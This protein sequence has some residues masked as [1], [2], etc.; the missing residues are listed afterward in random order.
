MTRHY[1]PDFGYITA[2]LTEE[3]DIEIHRD[4]SATG[5]RTIMPLG[6]VGVDVALDI[7][8]LSG[9]AHATIVQRI[10]NTLTERADAGQ[11]LCVAEM[12]S[13]AYALRSGVGLPIP[14]VQVPERG[15]NVVQFRRAV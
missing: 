5:K 12:R 11:P 8:H 3:G 9:Q 14:V 4:S 6:S 15:G 13:I 7:L 2:H 1:D 10:A